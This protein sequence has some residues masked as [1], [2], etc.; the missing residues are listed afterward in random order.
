MNSILSEL[1]N[2]ETAFAILIS[3]FIVVLV[4]IKDTRHSIGRVIK[5]FFGWKIQL[6]FISQ[7]IYALWEIGFWNK[8]LLKDSILWLFGVAFLFV[9]RFL[10]GV[11]FDFF[12]K[13]LLDSLKWT[14]LIEYVA[15]LYVFSLPIELVI[16]FMMILMGAMKPIAERDKK[17]KDVNSCL[18]WSIAILA[19]GTISFSVIKTFIHFNE[20]FSVANMKNIVLS[21]LLTILYLPLLYLIA[22]LIQYETLFVRIECMF[23]DKTKVKRIKKAIKQSAGLSISRLNNINKNF[24]KRVIY[25]TDDIHSYIK[26]L[27]QTK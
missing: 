24:L 17:Y 1:N 11:K 4:F 14:V 27:S 15:N 3:A 22:L 16:V 5:T 13:I 25:E 8:L 9:F 26:D 6:I 18:T 20:F 10:E 12:K 2:R 21:P 23:A 19:I 7:V